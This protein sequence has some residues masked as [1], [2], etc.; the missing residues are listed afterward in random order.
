MRRIPAWAGFSFKGARDSANRLPACAPTCASRKAAEDEGL[1]TE[2]IQILLQQ[3][4]VVLC[5]DYKMNTSTQAVPHSHPGPPLMLVALS[6]TALVIGGIIG[7][8]LLSPHAAFPMPY[9]PVEK[10]IAYVSAYPSGIRVGSFFQLAS[11]LPLGVFVAT[12]VSRL[13]FLRVRAAG[14]LIALCGGIAAMGMLI[15]S[16]LADWSLATP[17]ISTSAGAVRALQLL[18]FAAGGPGFVAPLGLLFAGVSIA[19]G[20]NRLIP[21]WL[22]WF[23]IAI[24]AACELSTLMLLTW[25]AA[26][27]IP[28]G[29]FLGIMWMIGIAASLP[30][31]FASAERGA[32]GQVVRSVHDLS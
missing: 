17:G 6:Y 2:R 20:L 10:A 9:D 16:A 5:N 29:R 4:I 19:A 18:G 3:Q 15:V 32:A 24:A 30:K 7:G 23:G 12:V 26:I 8:I 11:A 21:R 13:R 27:F 1:G 31:T 14:E 28:V 25:T 22:M